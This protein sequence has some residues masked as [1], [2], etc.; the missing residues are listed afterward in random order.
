MSESKVVSFLSR[1]NFSWQVWK[2]TQPDFHWFFERNFN[3]M[4][5]DMKQTGDDKAY[6]IEIEIP[7]DQI[8][9]LEKAF[10][11]GSLAT[12]IDKLHGMDP[13]QG[14]KDAKLSRFMVVMGTARPQNLTSQ[15]TIEGLE[16]QILKLE[17]MERMRSIDLKSVMENLLSFQLEMQKRLDG[18][19]KSLR[20]QQQK[21]MRNV[22][23]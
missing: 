11:D 23:G 9:K 2:E 7:S 16:E 22:I 15:K 10:K 3:A 19:R 12:E 20:R 1:S 6:V 8:G 13:L 21:W 5:V 4:T 14:K 18:L 17:Q